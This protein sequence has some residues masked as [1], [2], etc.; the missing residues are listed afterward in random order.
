MEPETPLFERA[1]VQKW[2]ESRYNIVQQWPLITSMPE[3]SEAQQ[4][5][6]LTFVQQWP[7]WCGVE[8]AFGMSVRFREYIFP[9]LLI[10]NFCCCL[11]RW[12]SLNESR[13]R[14]FFPQ[15]LGL[16]YIFCILF[17]SC[18]PSPLT[19]A[20][21]N[22]RATVATVSSGKCVDSEAVCE[23]KLTLRHS[24][25]VSIPAS[26]LGGPSFKCRP[27]DRLSWL[28]LP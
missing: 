5:P 18:L 27:G 16:L 2:E 26:Y 12:K 20:K 28:R 6:L 17:F 11:Y 1:V 24:R 8:N 9:V 7:T 19:N 25:V 4:W 15:L 21:N 3:W 23:S 14:E 13:L 10:Y 22:A